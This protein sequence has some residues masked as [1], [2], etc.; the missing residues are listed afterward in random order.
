MTIIQPSTPGNRPNYRR[1]YVFEKFMAAIAL[2]NYILVLFDLSYI[3]LRDSYLESFPGFTQ[4]YG[5]QFKG[6][7]PHRTTETYLDTVSELVESLEAN[8]LPASSEGDSRDA[9]VASGTTSLEGE[10]IADPD[11]EASDFDNFGAEPEADARA[12]GT[13]TSSA[14]P[15]SSSTGT[16]ADQ[17]PRP[18]PVL[19]NELR[20]MSAEIIDENPFDIAN[21]TGTLERI[22]QRMRERLNEESSQEAFATFWSVDHLRAAGWIEELQFFDSEIRPLFATN[23]FRNIGLDGRPTDLFI[24]IDIWFMALFAAEL[25]LRGIY[26][27]RRYKGT[28]L[29]D[30]ILWRWYDLI[31]LL[32]FWRWLRI[33]PVII[34]INQSNLI[35]LEPMSNRIR[36]LFVTHFAIEL[37]EIIIIRIIDQIQDLVRS[38]EVAKILLTPDGR[39]RYIDLNDINEVETITRRLVSI[40]VYKVLP[41]VRPQVEALLD[42]NLE[43]SLHAAPLY[44]NMKGLPGFSTLSHQLSQQVT[45]SVYENVAGILRSAVRDEKGAELIQSLVDSVVRNLQAEVRKDET[46]QEFESLIVVL[47]EEIKINYVQSLAAEDVEALREKTQRLYQITQHPK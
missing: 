47:L 19:L 11:A 21:K 44:S 34:R 22:K 18:V 10:Q 33:I 14:D 23:Y 41:E 26:L 16:A 46:V 15:N 8:G 42:H 43:R 2:L 9:S 36:R 31:L 35:D 20:F 17:S 27:S 39:R 30:A 1:S 38:G 12:A 29:I 3:P 32:P 6:I 13:A 28:N 7:E 40:L 37:T 24:K 5:E 4:W 45:H 25:L